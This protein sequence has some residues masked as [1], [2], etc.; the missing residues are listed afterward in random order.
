[1]MTLFDA[2]YNLKVYTKD[3]E[4]KAEARGIEQGIE[5]NKK[6]IAKSLL[7]ILDIETIALKTGLTTQEVENLK[8]QNTK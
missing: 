1:M 2:E 7:D 8:A 6:E 4:R 3:V 5:Q